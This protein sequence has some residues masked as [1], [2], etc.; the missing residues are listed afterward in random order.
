MIH[1]FACVM[2]ASAVLVGPPTVA[3]AQDATNRPLRQI[4]G[5]PVETIKR[6]LQRDRPAS[7]EPVSEYSTFKPVAPPEAVSDAQPVPA[8]P[9]N[10]VA[11]IPTPRLRP[12][13]TTDDPDEVADTAAIPASEP[14]GF[15][16]RFDPAAK[17]PVLTYP[18]KKTAAVSDPKP[19]PGPDPVSSRDVAPAAAAAFVPL[20]RLRSAASAASLAA[21]AQLASLPLQERNPPAAGTGN[22]RALGVVSVPID[23]IRKGAC[24]IAAP[25]RVSALDGGDIAL[26]QKAVLD[27]RT[28]ATL[29][30]W[31][32]NSVDPLARQYLRGNVTSIRVAASYTCR[33]RN[34]IAGAKLSEHGKGNAIDIS[35]FNVSGVGWVEVGKGRTIASRRFL[36]AVRKS[37]C[38]PFKTVL[39]PGSDGHHK[40]HFHFD[41]AQRRNGSVYCK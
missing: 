15:D 5:P 27:P 32:R 24:G 19:G 35:A 21:A 40:D 2:I 33:T 14:V 10:D 29:A 36:A 39:G 41:I 26:T 22:L 11:N 8:E 13:S 20:P 31:M 37:G 23:P 16:D 38:G 28:A 12:A 1:R 18:A 6:T 4:F 7:G 30:T 9:A 34:N 17:A 25:I 3:F